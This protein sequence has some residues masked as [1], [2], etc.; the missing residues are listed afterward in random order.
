VCDKLNESISDTP[1]AYIVQ[2]LEALHIGYALKPSFF[3]YNFP[4]RTRPSPKRP[5]LLG[6]QSGE[7]ALPVP[8]GRADAARGRGHC[9]RCQA[10]VP[11][12]HAEHAER[13]PQRRNKKNKERKKKGKKRRYG[14][15]HLTNRFCCFFSLLLLAAFG[16]CNG[17]SPALR[18]QAAMSASWPRPP[19]RQVA[20]TRSHSVL[21]LS[22]SLLFFNDFPIAPLSARYCGAG[23]GG[24]L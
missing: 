6:L 18:I 9:A 4:E 17:C 1:V 14:I 21:S 22:F 3:Y 11:N 7:A 2:A 19:V 15:N 23:A 10:N 13:I 20:L 24:Q 16:R 5:F 12:A 8:T